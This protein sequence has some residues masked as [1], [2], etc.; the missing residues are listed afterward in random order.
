LRF[1][2][3]LTLTGKGGV[4]L[5][6]T[7]ERSRLSVSKAT[8][9][10]KKSQLG[11]FFTP[12][13]TARFMAEMF[14]QTNVRDCHLLDAGAGI[15]SLSAAFLERCASGD[16]D[17]R[18]IGVD[19]F[20]IDTSLHRVLAETLNRYALSLPVTSNIYEDDFITASVNSINKNL[21]QKPLP[22]YTHAI[23]NPPYKKISSSSSHRAALRRIKIETV[24]LYSAFV[25]LSLSLLAEGGQLVAV[26]PRS[27]CN[28]PYYYPFRKYLLERATIR[29]IH[30]FSSR[31]K[32][33]RDDDVLQENIILL[34][35]HSREQKDVT[36]KT[37]TDDSFSDLEKH[38]YPF[39]RI[40]CPD[41]NQFII[42]VPTSPGWS[43][44]ERSS[45]VRYSLSDIG[46]NVSTGPVVDF[47]MK[48]YLSDMP[49]NGTVP[50]LYPNHFEGQ[51]TIWPKLGSKKA[52]AIHRNAATQKWLFPNGCYCVVRRFSSKEEKRRIKASVVR[53]GNFPQVEFLGFENHLNVFHS[54]KKGLPETL[55]YGLSL[56]L[57][58]SA[59][60][61]YFRRFNGHTQVNA[62]DLKLLKYPSRAALITLGKW[63]ASHEKV[64]Q[65]MIDNYLKFLL[66]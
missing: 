28:G 65:S 26:I 59:V 54:E 29:Q 31:N 52:N 15:G 17:F 20:E 21:F 23:L 39:E 66:K 14:E 61:E 33:F 38:I 8:N 41:N 45:A 18:H 40:V 50:L 32:A 6:S 11:Q 42:H 35:H 19:A 25:A 53:P 48:E 3:K 5:L 44:I 2:V 49:E 55:A 1:P 58:T 10:E 64:D 13:Q 37:S 4:I 24:N 7:L 22:K 34:L 57:N 16:F 36:I 51:D 27:F 62:T 46:V 9:A 60:D 43:S 63:A 56:F 30:L 47:R 12:V